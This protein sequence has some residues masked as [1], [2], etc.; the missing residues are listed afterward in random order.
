MFRG[1]D[2]DGS[3]SNH[4]HWQSKGVMVYQIENKMA[5]VGQKIL[6]AMKKEAV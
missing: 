6:I 1:T 5:A 4:V 3:S 2:H